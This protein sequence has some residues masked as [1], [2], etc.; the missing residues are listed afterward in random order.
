MATTFEVLVGRMRVDTSQ[1]NSNLAKA[2]QAT[3]KAAQH[4]S[5]MMQV[6]G[7]GVQNVAN[8]LGALAAAAGAVVGASVRIG[9]SFD[10]SMARVRAITGATEQQFQSLRKQAIK[11][12]E[13]TVF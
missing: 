8:A 3:G 10:Q 4:I 9:A 6:A 13:E 11:L 12:G 7:R 1:W 5:Q 2:G